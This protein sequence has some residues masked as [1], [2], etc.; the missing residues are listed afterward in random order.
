M[1]KADSGGDV[2]IE[3]QQAG[4]TTYTMGIDDSDSNVFKIHSHTALED[5]SDFKMDTSGN[6]SLGANLSLITD[7]SIIYF[8]EN[9]EIELTHDHNDG[10][11]LKNTKTSDNKS[12]KLTLLLLLTLSLLLFFLKA[13]DNSAV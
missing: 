5:T 11:K 3:F 8:G 6:I 7:G 2:T 9:S 10:L 12:V 4:T 13:E 1:T